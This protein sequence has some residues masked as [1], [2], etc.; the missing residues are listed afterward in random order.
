MYVR[1]ER[2]RYVRYKRDGT[3]VRCRRDRTYVRCRRDRN[4]V[5]HGVR[6]ETRKERI[7]RDRIQ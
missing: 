6:L 5:R 1:G 3:Y 2:N 4:Y 7:D